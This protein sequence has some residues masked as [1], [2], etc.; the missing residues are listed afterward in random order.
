MRTDRWTDTTKLIVAFRNFAKGP[1]VFQIK[2]WNLSKSYAV[3]NLRASVK[4]SFLI[5]LVKFGSNCT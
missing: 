5:D 3:H 2:V 4:K 1:K